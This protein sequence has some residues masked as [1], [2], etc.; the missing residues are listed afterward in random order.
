MRQQANFFEPK[1]WVEGKSTIPYGGD[2]LCT[3]VTYHP[4]IQAKCGSYHSKTTVRVNRSWLGEE[5]DMLSSFSQTHNV[6]VWIDQWGMRAE[7]AGGDAAQG[8]YMTDVLAEFTER[9]FHWTYWIWRRTQSWG[10][11]G[12]AIERQ[13]QDGSYSLF[14]L[15]LD[16]L[17]T[18]IG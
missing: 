14:Q 4:D 15:C 7:D 10:E 12:F 8:Q 16:Y 2:F 18:V 9:K 6:P 1:V 13:A 5:L 3:D 17:K 11:G